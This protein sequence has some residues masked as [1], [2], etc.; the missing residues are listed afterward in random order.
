MSYKR[1]KDHSDI[2]IHEAVDWIVKNCSFNDVRKRL[3]GRSA[4]WIVLNKML[5]LEQE[6]Q[7]LRNQINELN[8]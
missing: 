8:K 2:T 3:R 6:N 5:E 1:Q 7:Q 4:A